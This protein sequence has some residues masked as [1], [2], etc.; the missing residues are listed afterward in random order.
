MGILQA[1]ILEWVAMPFFR[2]SSRPRDRTCVYCVF[3]TAGGFFTAESRGSQKKLPA[4][5]DSVKEHCVLGHEAAVLGLQS[6]TVSR[7]GGKGL[8]W[9][10]DGPT[11][12]ASGSLRMEMNKMMTWM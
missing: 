3:C 6:E 11:L 9:A 8:C 2:G 5:A 1:G 4:Q 12:K 10:P 7:A